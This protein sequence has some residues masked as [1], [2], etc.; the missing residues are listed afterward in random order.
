MSTYTTLV[1]LAFERLSKE[2]GIPKGFVVA[3]YE[4][5]DS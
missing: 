2:L 5:K 3:L 4:D 1:E